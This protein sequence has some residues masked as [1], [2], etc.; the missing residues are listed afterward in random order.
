MD[1]TDPATWTQHASGPT[2][3]KTGI[4]YYDDAND[5][6]LGFIDMTTDAG[7]TA[8]SLADGDITVQFNASGIITITN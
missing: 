2:N 6:A 1:A 3:I 5:Y 4:L 8:I 7:T